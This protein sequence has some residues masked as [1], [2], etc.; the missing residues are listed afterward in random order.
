MDD[1]E[2]RRRAYAD[3]DCQDDDFLERKN[4]SLENTRFVN[5]LQAFDRQIKDAMNIPAPKK[6][7]E[8]IILNQAL[9][10]HSRVRRRMKLMLSLAASIVLVFSI[11]F[12]ALYASR[13][14]MEQEVLAHIYEELHH[15]DEQQ[16]NDLDSINKVLAMF[17]GTM[18]Q[19]IGKVNYL[20]G[21]DIANKKSVHMVLAGIKGPVTVMMLPNV[22]VKNMRRVSDERFKGFIFPATK[23]SMAIVGESG[24]PLDEIKNKMEKGIHWII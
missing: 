5:E 6:L 13:N 18:T 23:G 19:K 9:G 4:A 3:P 7:A 21:C 20:G 8:R 24:E 17:G 2:F 15:L 10:Q 12:T 1:L 16:N 11:M 14:D 22:K